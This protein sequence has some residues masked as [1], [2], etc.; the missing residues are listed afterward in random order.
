MRVII[1]FVFITYINHA[2]AQKS[3]ITGQIQ[4]IETGQP[5]EL[6]HVFVANTTTGTTTDENGNFSL[7]NLGFGYI[8]LVASFVGYELFVKRVQIDADKA[9]EILIKMTPQ[10]V[11]LDEVE[12][13]VKKD[14]KW[15]RQLKRFTKEFLGTGSN[16]RRCEILNPWVIDFEQDDTRGLNIASADSHIEVLNNALGYKVFFYLKHFLWGSGFISYFGY[17]RFEA[18]QAESKQQEKEW[19]LN[20]KSA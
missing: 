1:F 5:I 15:E 10:L 6:V 13:S 14:R 11:K 3:F 7:E 18:L 12:I 8:D 19:E 4:N 2:I 9:I 17:P 20:R 16:A